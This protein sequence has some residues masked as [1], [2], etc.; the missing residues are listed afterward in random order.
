MYSRHEY[1]SFKKKKNKQI[2]WIE[3]PNE[4]GK[5]FIN[6]FNIDSNNS[7]YNQLKIFFQYQLWLDH[8]IYS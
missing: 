6:F 1:L 7:F 4:L 8:P 5:D 3:R 2:G